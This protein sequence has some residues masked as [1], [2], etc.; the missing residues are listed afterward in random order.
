MASGVAWRCIR[1]VTLVLLIS[2]SAPADLPPVKQSEARLLFTGDIL[3]SRQV[4]AEIKKT[5]RSPWGRMEK[6][7]HDA[8]WVGGNLEGAIGSPAECLESRSPCFAVPG[9]DVVFLQQAGFHGVTIENNHSG[10]LGAAGRTRTH[11][12]LSKAGLEAIDFEH[13]PQ[14]IRAGGVKFAMV[15]ITL[16][17][18]ADRH[19]QSLPSGEVLAKLRIAR[20]HADLVVVS[21]HWGNE[22]IPW[23]GDSQRNA[24]LWL[25]EH[26][27]DLVLGH[28]PHVIQPP[29]CVKGKPV[30]FSLGNHVFDQA[31]PK[32]R[33]GM[34][35][36]CRIEAG[37]LRCQSIATHTA[38]GTSSPGF[39]SSNQ[40]ANSV[41]L[42]CAPS[43]AAP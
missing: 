38:P 9:D 18:S 43:V 41:L 15:A 21:I 1:V 16:I 32:T 26:G 37:R 5:G 8:D 7:F 27:A 33:D 14:F 17:P 40:A 28:H 31:N 29:E 12:A 36:D 4:D 10:D 42:H 13:S 39:G 24:A 6:L 2:P 22:F 30:F 23:P 3:L 19:V 20:H 11:E 25:I 34:I 35:A